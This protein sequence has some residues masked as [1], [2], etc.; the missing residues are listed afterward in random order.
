VEANMKIE[1]LKDKEKVEEI[2]V[3]I[4]WDQSEIQERFGKKIK[5]V[6]VANLDSKQGDGTPTALLDLYNENI[7]KYK[8]GDKI[9]IKDA[10]S[11]LIKNDSGQYRLTNVREMEKIE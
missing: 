7:E 9:K 2:D 5:S 6:F 10:Y 4:I 11:K 3:K 1:D 8:Q